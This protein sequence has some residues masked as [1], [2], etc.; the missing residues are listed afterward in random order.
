MNINEILLRLD[1]VQGSKGKYR[2]RCPSHASRGLTLAV[3][4]ASN[5]DVLVKCFAGCTASEIVSSI[6]L[7]L[8]DLF[9]DDGD[10]DQWRDRKQKKQSFDDWL[11]GELFVEIYQADVK[12]GIKPTDEEK[13]KYQS[14]VRGQHVRS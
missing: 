13:Q 2:A 10:L 9:A 8:S 3:K 12:R 4:E 14:I 11:Y 6:G 5:G 7:Q 1:K